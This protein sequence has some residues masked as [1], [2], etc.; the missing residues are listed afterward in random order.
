MR[1][2]S[3]TRRPVAQRESGGACPGLQVQI[4]FGHERHPDT[5]T[6]QSIP[7][8]VI[9]SQPL[10]NPFAAQQPTPAQAIPLARDVAPAPAQA[11]A[12][13][14][15]SPF[16]AAATAPT[17]GPFGGSDVFGAPAPRRARAPRLSDL[18]QSGPGQPIVNRLL[19]VAPIRIEYGVPGV[20]GK[21]QDRL[22]M[23]IAV[24][25]GPPIVY[26]GKPEKMGGSQHDQQADV[27]VLFEEVYDSHVGIIAATRDALRNR[28]LG[29]APWMV[30]GRLFIGTA[31]PGQNP[32]FL[33]GRPDLPMAEQPGAPTPEDVE[34][35]RRFLAS[36]AA[37][38]MLAKVS[39]RG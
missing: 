27:P 17:A 5:H 24:L 22:T 20:D 33:I 14:A 16:Q 28:M 25:D 39:A 2:S 29:A 38:P 11:S 12:P 6:R 7:K 37:A 34:L 23:D 18:L 9:V 35:A 13:A 32:P 30:L 1:V 3:T 4:L 21:P 36:E 15:A 10:Y 19:L 31:K 26:G 8:G